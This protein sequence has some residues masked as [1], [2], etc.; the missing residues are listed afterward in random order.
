MAETKSCLLDANPS[1][2]P[3]QIEME[4][5]EAWIKY[6]V[7]SWSPGK[8]RSVLEAARFLRRDAG[9]WQVNPFK[10]ISGKAVVIT[11]D[12]W[13]DCKL[14]VAKTKQ[15]AYK[16][17]KLDPEVDL[18]MLLSPDQTIV[19]ITI[20]KTLERLAIK[21]LIRGLRPCGGNAFRLG[22]KVIR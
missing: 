8:L 9:A 16:I 11:C 12:S 15:L 4:K 10:V 22:E 17:R 21:N 13:K 6:F 19:E 1:L 5:L 7:F 2:T 3:A 18:L 14:L 20:V